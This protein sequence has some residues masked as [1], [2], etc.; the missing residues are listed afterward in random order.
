MKKSILKSKII[1]CILFLFLLINI[2]S[3]AQTLPSDK[4]VLIT[5][6]TI[7][8]GKSD[9]PFMY[10]DFPQYSFSS[11]TGVLISFV[12]ISVTDTTK[13]I[14]GSGLSLS[15][16]VG[17]GAATGLTLYD[18]LVSDGLF[19]I[20]TD[21]SAGVFYDGKSLTLAAGQSWTETYNTTAVRGFTGQLTVSNYVTNFG[22]QDKNKI[23]L[24]Y[25]T[26]TEPTPVPTPQ[27]T[28]LPGSCG[29]ANNDNRVDIL[30]ALLV[31]QYY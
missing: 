5:S 19:S 20:G 2:Q 9:Q 15:S 11:T 10:I 8:G 16:T 23:S 24:P 28:I 4:Y 21:G 1:L 14:Y 18:N 13:V 29:D 31:A 30:D 17:S 22:I 26:T 27:A 12:S 7:I 6:Y 25:L 3:F